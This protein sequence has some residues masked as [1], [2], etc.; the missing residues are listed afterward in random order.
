MNGDGKNQ[1]AE[2]KRIDVIN[3]EWGHYAWKELW[4]TQR[5][6]VDF[7]NGSSRILTFWDYENPFTIK[8][9][10]EDKLKRLL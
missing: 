5:L 1:I 8:L 3:K 6:I 9:R 2:V 7:K 10:R 4:H